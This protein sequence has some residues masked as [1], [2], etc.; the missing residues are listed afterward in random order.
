M[1]HRTTHDEIGR[2]DRADLIEFLS[3]SNTEF[4]VC[5]GLR[6]RLLEH[7]RIRIDTD[8]PAGRS[9]LREPDGELTGTAPDIYDDGV[10]VRRMTRDERLVEDPVVFGLWRILT[11][12][13]GGARTLVSRHGAPSPRYFVA[14]NRTPS[15]VDGLFLA[16]PTSQSVHGTCRRHTHPRG[17]NVYSDLMR[18]NIVIDDQLLAEAQRLSGAPTKRATVEFA[19]QELVRRRARRKVLDLQGRVEWEGDLG[20]SR[21]SA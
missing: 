1:E 13:P 14:R 15:I 20:K 3:P 19:L 18:T 11:S 5:P 12:V 8:H 7:R 17:A 4:E 9:E 6:L 21:R 10:G 16:R 2:R